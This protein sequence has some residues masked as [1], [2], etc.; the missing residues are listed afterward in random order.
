M[1]DTGAPEAGRGSYFFLSY[2]YSPP[3]AGSRQAEPD[4]WVR[5]FFE[6]L[7]ASV[8]SRA[9]RPGPAAPGGFF[10]QA[11]P[12]GADRSGALAEVLGATQVFV[13]LLSPGYFAKAWPGREWACF[14]RRL[15]AVELPDPRRRF[16]PVL[17]IPLPE[18]QRPPPGLPEALALGAGEPAYAENGLRAL[19]RIRPYRDAYQGV[20][21]RLARRI[22]DLAERA[23]IPPSAVPDIR[24]VQSPFREETAAAVFAVTVAA[25]TADMAPEGCDPRR[26]GGDGEDWRPFPDL[27][28]LRLTDYA[29]EAAE[30]LDFAAGVIGIE[31]AG[32]QRES[33]PGMLLIDPWFAAT[34]SG[35]RVLRSF[36]RNLPPWV[37]PAVI[38]D[39]SADPRATE[40]AG[41]VA[42]ILNAAGALHTETARRAARGVDSLQS[43]VALMPLLVT[44]AERQY[45]RH[46]PIRRP[47]VPP[48]TRPRLGG[49]T[50]AASRGPE[51]EPGV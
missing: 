1:T 39:P 2:A 26:Y 25:P 29:V 10:D 5:R 22:V 28:E 21:D 6:D 38:M 46:R 41:R 32:D 35:E 19:L 12:V 13:P 14:Y 27:Q 48:G 23:P 36:L 31:K 40:L 33:G 37:L 49:G 50:T 24:T 42:A 4:Q 15:T 7:D 34:E 11:I 9:R 3:L 18:E 43:F 51:E 8:R 17:W 20:V 45:L 47:T 44:E 16:A 30:R